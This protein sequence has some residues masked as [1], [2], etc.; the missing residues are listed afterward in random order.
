MFFTSWGVTSNLKEKD[1]TEITF[2]L[3]FGMK[4]GKHEKY[5]VLLTFNCLSKNVKKAILT[6]NSTRFNRID[7]KITK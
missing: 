2:Q 6:Y 5:R 3:V 1:E 7:K 4:M